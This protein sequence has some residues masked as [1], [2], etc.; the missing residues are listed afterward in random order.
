MRLSAAIFDLDGTLLDSLDDLHITMC[1]VLK[2]GGFPE[3]SKETVRH[4]IGRGAREFMRLSLPERARDEDT[5]DFFLLRYHQLY[6]RQGLILTKPYEGVKEVL[7]ELKERNIKIAVL[8]NKPHLSTLEVV[9]NFFPDIAFDFVMGQQDIFPP[10]PDTASAL[11]MAG[12]LGVKPE[13]AAFIGDGDADTVTAIKGGFYQVSV[14]WGYRTKEELIK[15]G[16]RNFI[17]SPREIIGLFE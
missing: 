2:E 6:N 1:T 12:A 5:I 15:A 7:K 11:Y 17:T 9:K 3:I 14:L 13:E 4:L 10:K 8:S 16:A